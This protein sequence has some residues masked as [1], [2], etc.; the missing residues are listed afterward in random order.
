ME[1]KASYVAV[2]AFVLTCMLGLVITL[3]WLAG[4]QY[5][6]EYAYYQTYFTGPVNGL[7]KGTTVRYNGIDVGRVDDVKFDPN[8]PQ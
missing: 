1:T 5:N 6:T 8:D 2:G 7:G 3:L 4:L